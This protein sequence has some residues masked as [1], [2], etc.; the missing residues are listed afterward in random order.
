VIFLARY[1]RECLIGGLLILAAAVVGI[2]RMQVNSC[3]AKLAQF[4]GA[5]KALSRSV[6]VQNDAIQSLEKKS[7]ETAQRAAL[8]RAQAGEATRVAKTKADALEAVLA[9]PRPTSACPSFDALVVVRDDLR[10][11]KQTP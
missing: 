4:E 6:Q 9:A 7:A 1:W 3:R 11:R 5:Y 8:L 10:A 2:S